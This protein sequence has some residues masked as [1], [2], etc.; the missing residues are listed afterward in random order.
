MSNLFSSTFFAKWTNSGHTSLDIFRKRNKAPMETMSLAF[1]LSLL[2]KEKGMGSFLLHLAMNFPNWS[3][4]L[5][6]QKNHSL[7]WVMH[8]KILN[9]IRSNKVVL[10]IIIS[11]L[12]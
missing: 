2:T 7:I 10:F 5:G 8:Q 12:R 4:Q 9:L 6:L 1:L 11:L 3:Q